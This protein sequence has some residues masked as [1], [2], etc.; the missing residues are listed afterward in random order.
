MET[1]TKLQFIV[2]IVLGTRVYFSRFNADLYHVR[3]ITTLQDGYWIGPVR[4]L[5][6]STKEFFYG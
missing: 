3:Q 2:R 5:C 6:Y 4:F 1:T